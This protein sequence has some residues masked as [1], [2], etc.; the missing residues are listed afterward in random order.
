MLLPVF[1]IALLLVPALVGVVWAADKEFTDYPYLTTDGLAQA[2]TLSTL[3]ESPSAMFCNPAALPIG[4]LPRLAHNHSARHF[5][6]YE[7]DAEMDQLDNDFESI[8]FP[9][10]LGS[11]GYGF[12]LADEGGYD[13]SNHPPGRF[14]YPRERVKGGEVCAA[15]SLGW[16]PFKTGVS[17]RKFRREFYPPE[18]KRAPTLGRKPIPKFA[19]SLVSGEGYSRGL[20][21]GLPWFRYAQVSSCLDMRE[22]QLSVGGELVARQKEKRCGW[23]FMPLAWLSIAGEKSTRNR[24]SFAPEG[25]K[26]PLVTDVSDARSITVKPFAF[27]E[28]SVG[29]VGGKRAWGCKL[30]LPVISLKYAEIKDYLGKIVGTIQDTFADLHFYSFDLCLF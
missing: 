22:I 8:I 16:Y 7:G 19:S 11:F 6:G 12:T 13:Y 14:P 26:T 29:K 27:L 20:I 25:A 21:A 10:P 17:L 1:G 23:R 18:G 24:W 3:P 9:L 2:M 4:F 28:L 15:Y 5:P 30:V